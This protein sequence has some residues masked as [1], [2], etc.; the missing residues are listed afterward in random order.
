MTGSRPDAAVFLDRDGTLIRD[1]GYLRR[2]DEVEV[3]PKV[4]AA[5]RLLRELGFKLV[6]VTNQSAV[7]RGW[8][9]E[10]DLG[11]IHG[12]LAAKLANGGA[13]LDAVYYCPHHPVEGNGIYRV[14]CS[15]RKPGVGMIARASADLGLNPAVSY[16]VGDQKIDIELAERI[17]ATALLIRGEAASPG[18]DDRGV[19]VVA[20][21]WQ[22]AH[23]IL[24]H[25]KRM[26][27]GEE[28]QS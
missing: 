5:L 4:P 28:L 17:G 24:D 23:W 9:T 12:A 25:C 14:S 21:L 19:S 7:A 22:A 10:E 26:K 16:V 2:V 1:V 3:L 15:C 6:L 20:D 11:A 8:L 27:R 18:E 13:R